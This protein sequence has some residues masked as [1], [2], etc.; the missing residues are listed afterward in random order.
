MGNIW[1]I[2]PPSPPPPPYPPSPP[3]IGPL[4]WNLDLEADI[5]AS[6][7]R[8]RPRGLRE[9]GTEEEKE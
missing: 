4:G 5:W 6:R 7:L 8:Y 2:F 9:G 1:E 3:G